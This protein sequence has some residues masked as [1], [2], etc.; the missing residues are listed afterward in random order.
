MSRRIR[1]KSLFVTILLLPLFL[2]GLPLAGV[3]WSGMDVSTYLQFPPTTTFVQHAGFSWPVFVLVAIFVVTVCGPFA[4][5]IIRGPSPPQGRHS[6]KPF[7]GWG[8]FGVFLLISTWLLAW[9]RF[10]WFSPLQHYTFFPLWLGYIITVNGLTYSRIGRCL[11]V[12]EPVFLLFLFPVSAVFWWFFEYLNRFAQNWHY[13]GIESF[14]ALEYVCH[15][16]LCFSTVLPA[17]MSTEEFLRTL[18]RFSRTLTHLWPLQ[19]KSIRPAGFLVLLLFSAGLACI[20]IYPDYL[21]PLLWVSPFLIIISVQIMMGEQ[22]ILASIRCGDWLP[23]LLPAM[24]ALVCGFFWEMWNYKSL[25]HWEYSVPFVQRFH[26]F[27]MPLLGYAGY[28]PFGLEC[29]VVASLSR[30]LLMSITRKGTCSEES[31]A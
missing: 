29:A 22:T 23:V 20:S 15:A 4:V 24:A 27:E 31:V 8:L 16:T 21:F 12:S 30:K 10:S 6:P 17:V 13:L 5:K 26:V 7:P 25:A 18:T 3:W 14:S 9:S 1:I 19:V 11:M 28:L 2:V